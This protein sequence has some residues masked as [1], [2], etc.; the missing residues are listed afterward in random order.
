[1]LAEASSQLLKDFF[2]ERR[3]Q[4]KALRDERRAAASRQALHGMD[5]VD[6]FPD[7]P[8]QIPV[9]HVIELPDEPL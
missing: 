4:I 9:G 3:A 5:V 2:A 7:E 8:D 1:V 6:H